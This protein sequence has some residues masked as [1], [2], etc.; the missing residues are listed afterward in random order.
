[1]LA[2]VDTPAPDPVDP[3]AL[4]AEIVELRAAITKIEADLEFD[5][6]KPPEWRVRAISALAHKRR[7]LQDA[8][9]DLRRATRKMSGTADVVAAVAAKSQSKAATKLL[10]AS[11][12]DAE[13]EKRRMDRLNLAARMSFSMAFQR[14]AKEALP[15]DVFSGLLE[16]AAKIVSHVEKQEAKLGRIEC[17]ANMPAG[18]A[19]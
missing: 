14:A 15:P 2:I 13:A 11:R 4:H 17:G 16:A 10:I 19:A 3:E 6:T 7:R 12:V 9:R 8:E 1:M 18:D 5:D